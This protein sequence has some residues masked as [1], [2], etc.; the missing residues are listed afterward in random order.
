MRDWPLTC[1][2]LAV[3]MACVQ[4]PASTRNSNRKAF[5]TLRDIV[6][7][8]SASFLLEPN[9]STEQQSHYCCTLQELQHETRAGRDYETSQ[10]VHNMHNQ[11]QALQRS[12][13]TLSDA[14]LDELGEQKPAATQT[15]IW[16]VSGT[17]GKPMHEALS[18][19][20]LRVVVA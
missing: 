5:Y 18:H 9:L 1:H 10:T 13:M 14:L 8:C 11:L 3:P 20:W 17:L 15:A 2:E 12:F 19:R 16:L 6:K 4:V 7:V